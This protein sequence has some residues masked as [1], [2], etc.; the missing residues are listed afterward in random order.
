[1]NNISVSG[2][3]ILIIVD[4]GLDMNEVSM[5]VW[6]TLGNIEPERDIR[7]IK[8]ET[9]TLCLIVDATRKSKLSQFKRD[10]PNVIVSDDTTIKNIDE[11]W[12]TLELGDFIH[13]PSKK[14]KQMIF[15][16]GASVKE[17]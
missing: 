17:K 15:S 7:I 3:K 6:V 14:F 1:L 5:L 4:Y 13:S 12:K 16:E 9:E 8:P 11:K 2:I 10:W